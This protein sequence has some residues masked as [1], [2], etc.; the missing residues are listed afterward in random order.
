L[1]TY[2][3]RKITLKG[4]RP[5]TQIQH[6]FE[7]YYLYGAVSIPDGENLFW[8]LPC[9]NA[10]CFQFYINDL[11]EKFPDTMN[12]LLSD[13]AAIHKAK[14]LVIPENIYLMFLPACS[15]ELNP[16]ERFWQYVKKFL[17]NKIFSDLNHMKSYVRKLLKGIS[18]HDAASV[19]R[20]SY[21]SD[22]I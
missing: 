12:V 21:I 22:A 17:K 3:G 2:L 8:E 16:I 15:P 5:V 19:T 20:F 1:I 10:D 14:R 4:V 11:S 7:N 6:K 9:M 13:N 18:D